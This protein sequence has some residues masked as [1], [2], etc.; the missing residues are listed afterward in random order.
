MHHLQNEEWLSLLT[1]TTHDSIRDWLPRVTEYCLFVR[2]SNWV[3]VLLQVLCI[4][5][6]MSK[7]DHLVYF[8]CFKSKSLFRMN[9]MH[10]N[11]DNISHVPILTWLGVT[12]SFTSHRSVNDITQ[13]FSLNSFLLLSFD[14]KMSHLKHRWKVLRAN[15]CDGNLPFISIN[16]SFRKTVSLKT[17]LWIFPHPNFLINT[18]TFDVSN[19]VNVRLVHHI[20]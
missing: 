20:L 4:H 2:V 16:V 8:F 14:T 18:I 1:V 15:Q 13:H 3:A 12:S 19:C 11:T 10:G 9:L 6:H 7:N 5:N 17:F